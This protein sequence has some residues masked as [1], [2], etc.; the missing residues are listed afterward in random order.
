[1][2]TPIDYNSFIHPHDRA[3]LDAIKK[4]PLFDTIIRCWMKSYV[5]RIQHA[6][7]MASNLRLGPQQLPEIHASLV[8]I[9]AKLGIDEPELYVTTARE[10]NAWTFG[11]SKPFITL[12]SGLLEMMDERELYSTLAHECGHILC[13]HTLYHMVAEWLKNIGTGFMG[14]G[15]VAE[16]I[17][18]AFRYWSRMSEFSADRVAVYCLGETDTFIRESLRFAGGSTISADKLNVEA[19]VQQAENYAEALEKSNYEKSLQGVYLL[20]QTHPFMTIRCL[21]VRKWYNEQKDNLP[22]PAN[23]ETLA[24]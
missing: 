11:D 1:M 10:P 24:W 4:I 22:P 6:I 21:E 7:N 8:D 9:C 18:L 3:A 2:P 19:F 20:Q 14:L 23:V 12:T 16:P 5:E 17:K 15:A 13:H